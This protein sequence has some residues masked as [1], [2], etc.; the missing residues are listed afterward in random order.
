VDVETKTT[1]DAEA[2]RQVLSV[3]DA[4][5]ITVGIVIGVGI[6]KTP[7]SVA[8]F[9]GSV[10][11]SI[12]AWIGGALLSLVGALTYSE[13]AATYPSAG[14]DYT[15]LTRAYGRNVSFFFA[16]SSVTVISTGSV[17]LL[18]FALGDYL[19]QI[20][21][22]GTYSSAI[23]AGVSVI[24]LT[25]INLLGLKQSARLQNVT[26]LIE[27]GGVLL[28]AVAGLLVTPKTHV[29]TTSSSNF[30]LF[31]T[32]MVFVLLTYGGWNDCAYVSAEVRGG[33]RAI[34]RTLVISIA[35]IGAVYVSFI[36]AVLHGLGFEGLKASEALGTDLM[37]AAFGGIG[38]PLIAAIVAVSALTSMNG[39]MIVGA[40]TNYSVANDWPLF[41]FMSGWH[42]ERNTPYVGFIVQAIIALGLIGFGAFQQ[43][44]FSAMVEFTAPVF[45]FFFMMSG[46]ALFIL[47]RK[48]PTISRPFKVPLY[49]VLPLIFVATC[50]YLFYSSIVYAQS[51]KKGFVS[52]VVVAV[53]AVV[54]GIARMRR[55]ALPQTQN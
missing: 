35:L 29:A 8:Q 39:T 37:Q 54:W 55:T 11:L 27:I 17:A 32:A 34:L 2:P 38:A 19:S 48:N 3:F 22:L 1:S 15:F 49:P 25:A 24:L 7:A 30:G 18:G 21:N 45:W 28:V 31:G 4:V 52:L 40:R 42:G 46:I 50:A 36:F 41:R 26:T 16:W 20:L 9:T 13:L 51:Q 10:S 5:M 43:N 12:A 14:G 47:R 44:G 6:F 33:G 23:Y 53:G